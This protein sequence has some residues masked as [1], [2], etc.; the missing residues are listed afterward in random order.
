MN[1]VARVGG[2]GRESI[3]VSA[4]LLA[5]ATL[6][7]SRSIRHRWLAPLERPTG[8]GHRR[9]AA[10]D[11]P[12]WSWPWSRPA[13]SCFVVLWAT[14]GTRRP[15][16]GSA[17]AGTGATCWST[18]RSA[19]ASRPATSRREV[20]YFAGVPL[21]YHWF[22]DF[23]GAITSTVAGVDL[24]PVYFLTSA[25]FAGVLALVVWALGRPPDRRRRVA[26]DR[27]RSSSASAAGWAGSGSS[28]T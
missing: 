20:P 8:A 28:A 24:I 26:A 15:T 23:H 12:A 17:A 7:L 3:I 27:R 5:L 13:S 4:V 14:A 2:F 6:G 10:D 1:V 25:L 16:A 11:G 9:R 22:A 18:S 19:R 21:T